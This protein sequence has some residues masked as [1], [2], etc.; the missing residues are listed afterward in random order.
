MCMIIATFDLYTFRPLL[1]TLAYLKVTKFGQKLWLMCLPLDNASR[2]MVCSSCLSSPETA[3]ERAGSASGAI[4]DPARRHPPASAGLRAAGAAQLWRD[5]AAGLAPHPERDW[6]SQ[7][8]PQVRTSTPPLP[9]P[10]P[11]P[12]PPPPPSTAAIHRRVSRMQKLRSSLLKLQNGRKFYLLNLEYQTVAVHV[13][14]TAKNFGLSNVYP[15]GSFNF[16][17]WNPRETTEKRRLS[18]Q[19]IRLVYE[20]VFRPNRPFALNLALS[21]QWPTVSRKWVLFLFPYYAQ[22]SGCICFQSTFC[23]PLGFCSW[24]LGLALPEKSQLPRGR[25]TQPA[26]HFYRCFRIS[27]DSSYMECGLPWML[28]AERSES[29]F[30]IKLP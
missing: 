20:A 15:P 14:P 9:S 7:Q 10:L 6:G 2:L 1:M 27:A 3:G 30:L 25:A 13:S 26:K 23:H 28:A 4:G 18:L 8:G 17:F 11:T 5:A 19:R 24:E 22:K 16:I 29:G 12:P 21:I